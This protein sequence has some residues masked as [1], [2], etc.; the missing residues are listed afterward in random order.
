MHSSRSERD[1][2]T[3]GARWLSLGLVAAM[4]TQAG[5]AA[6][7]VQPDPRAAIATA[8]PAAP[9]RPRIGLV[10][11]GGGAKG[12]AHVGVLTLLEDMRIPVDCIVGT[13]MG[14]LVGGTYASGR[15]AADVE[16]A[17]GKIAW[18][19]TIG[20]A[21]LR[22][23][24]PMR[25]KLTGQTYS[26]RFEFGVRDGSLT[27]PT[28]IINTQNIEQTI[29]Y[30]V[31]G[32]LATDDFDA[33]PIPF[34]AVATDMMSGEMVVLAQGDLAQS[35]RASM[36]VPGVFAPVQ[37]DGR[38]L[39]DGGLTRNLPVDIA[40]QTCADVVIAVA[41][42]T[43]VPEPESLQSPL[44]M[45]S[46]T[47]DVLIGA[48]E[49]EQLDSLG[50]QDVRI[51][52]PMGDIGTGSFDRVADAIPLGR[53]AAEEQ[54]ES[55]RRYSLPAAEYLAWREATR[56]PGAGR[57][58]L[59]EVNVQGLGRVDEQYVRSKL[60]LEAGQSVEQ[61][62]V[63]RAV[64]S[65][66]A[67]GDFDGVQY[68]LRGDPARPALDVTF[69]EKSVAPNIVRFDIG[70]AVGSDGGNAF[71]LAADYLRPWV[72]SGG[73]ELHGQ[74]LLGRK[75][76]L[77]FAFYQPLDAEHR[78][79]VEPSARASR[80]TEDLYVGDQIATRYDFDESYVALDIG[81][82]FG[83]K[84]AV[85][86]GARNGSQAA[87]R[88]IAFPGLPDLEREAYGGVSASVIYDD[89]NFDALATRGWLVKS[90]YFRGLDALGSRQEYDRLEGL[91]MRTWPLG[92]DLLLARAT[93]GANFEGELPFYDTFTL[94]G[95]ISFPGLGI[96]QLRGSSYWTTSVTF[97]RKLGD[98]SALFDQS[99]YFGATL[100][101]GDMSGR[102]D[103]IR[104]DP[105]VGASLLLGARTPLGPLNVSFSATTSD[106]YNLVLTLGRP[107]EERNISDPG[108]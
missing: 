26:N 77:D 59:A 30:L 47:L 104:E 4:M 24:Q 54:R 43:P 42:P 88:E 19:E 105:L 5:E 85:R 33:L 97:L 87:R 14:A 31:A 25:R 94:G 86:V 18:A 70:F 41:V 81:R 92:S 65:L 44:A 53:R 64:D 23:K 1:V 46:R 71:V 72:N 61:K 62:E 36:A 101:G 95:P 20:F 79:F 107:I 102:I 56:Y 48:N 52:V 93:G 37:L 22:E 96:G 80:S 32:S 91:L 10:L 51:V 108:L 89:R 106:D 100:T 39:A 99:I 9:D 98:I 58:E 90:T 35:M 34:R 75:S 17:M 27:A 82:E 83:S 49:R 63:A 3:Y 74:L 67:L 78:W 11:G 6:A 15:T 55:L 40:R 45:I 2:G 76:M 12:A 84:A 8:A 73:G 7:A 66:F 38:T 60:G 28:G 29:R 57:I 50:P 68:S 21:G 103:R 16:R 13:S 69:A